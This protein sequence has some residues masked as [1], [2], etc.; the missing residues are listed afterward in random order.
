[1]LVTQSCVLSCSVV[2]SSLRPHRDCS[3]LGSSVHGIS[4]ARKTGM[5]LHSLL[6]GI[7][8]TQG[9][10]QGL[11]HCAHPLLLCLVPES[12]SFVCQEPALGSDSKNI[13]TPIFIALFT[14]AKI[15]KES[16][17]PPTD[18]WI[19]IITFH[20]ERSRCVMHNY[21]YSTLSYSLV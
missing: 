10:N 7:F 19:K 18:E 2:S 13:C 17:Y 4:Q 15:W 11:L 16:K 21:T 8:P 3:P 6:Q 14:I 20:K 5:H 9:L 12:G 1:M